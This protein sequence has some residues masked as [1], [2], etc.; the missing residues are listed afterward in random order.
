MELCS[1][2]GHSSLER[3][4]T[5]EEYGAPSKAIVVDR[6]PHGEALG[7]DVLGGVTINLHIHKLF[8]KGHNYPL[9]EYRNHGSHIA[10]LGSQPPPMRGAIVESLV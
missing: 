2:T 10:S 8:W 3:D 4:R 1:L 7:T 5:D 6:L 9:R